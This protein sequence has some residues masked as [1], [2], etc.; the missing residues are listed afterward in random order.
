MSKNPLTSPSSQHKQQAKQPPLN[1]GPE[2][3]I[4]AAQQK[5]CSIASSAERSLKLENQL[6]VAQLSNASPSDS[7]HPAM[8]CLAERPGLFRRRGSIVATYRRRNGRTFG[9]YYR[10]TYREDGHQRS[11]YLGGPGELLDQVREKLRLLQQPLKQFRLFNSLERE[12]RASLRIEKAKL[13]MLLRSHGLSMKGF[14]VRGWRLS[15]LRPAASHPGIPGLPLPA[16]S[17]Q[18]LSNPPTPQSPPLVPQL[19]LQDSKT[20]RPR[21]QSVSTPPSTSL[22]ATAKNRSYAGHFATRGGFPSFDRQRR[23]NPYPYIRQALPA[24][25][26]VATEVQH[27]KGRCR[28]PPN[29]GQVANEPFRCQYGSKL[30]AYGRQKRPVRPCFAM[31]SGSLTVSESINV[32]PLQ[33]PPHE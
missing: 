25:R 22:P 33:I 3:P 23:R 10:L 5:R 14:E 13:A 18:P 17:K 26:S 29:E 6:S 4:L 32:V 28:A 8:R 16:V 31:E 24:N 1:P 15:P 2:N 20:R 9:P 7:D 30:G 21:R 12:S 27:A 19:L 11:I